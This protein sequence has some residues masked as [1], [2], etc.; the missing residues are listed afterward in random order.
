[1]KCKYAQIECPWR[2]PFHELA[3]HEASCAQPSKTGEE[4]MGILRTQNHIFE[5]E[6]KLYRALFDLLSY[7]KIH[8]SGL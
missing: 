1:M 5:E 4:V 2:G 3:G 6:R 7:E 8:F